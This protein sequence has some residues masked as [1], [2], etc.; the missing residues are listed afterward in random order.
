LAWPRA[1]S[2]HPAS[3]A[4]DSLRRSINNSSP[5]DFPDANALD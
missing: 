1:G 3:E 4:K 2:V 5:F